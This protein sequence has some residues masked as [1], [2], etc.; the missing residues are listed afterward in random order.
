VPK[1]N[2]ERNTFVK[3]LITEASPLTFPENASIA[4]D[5]FVLHREGSRQRRLGM[6]YE[7]SHTMLN[8]GLP[9][10]SFISTAITGFR[11]ENADNNPL[12]TLCCVQVGEMLWFLDGFKDNLSGNVKGS[13]PLSSLSDRPTLAAQH[14]IQYAAI[15][16]NLILVNKYFTHPQLIEIEVDGGGNI[17]FFNTSINIKV[18]DIWGVGETTPV[19]DRPDLLTVEH[20]YNLFNQG[21]NADMVSITGGGTNYP[22]VAFKSVAGDWPSNADM[23]HVGKDGSDNFSANLILNSTIG[24]R[25]AG[26]G[27]VLL[28]IF[29]RGASRQQFMTD[30][31]DAV[32]RGN[33]IFLETITD[34]TRDA[35]FLEGWDYS[36]IQDVQ[37]RMN[38]IV[39]NTS[40]PTRSVDVSDL[41]LDAES[42]A[43]TTVTAYAG[44]IFYAGVDSVVTEGDDNTPAYASTIFFSQ[45]G[46]NVDNLSKCYSINDPTS[47]D[48]NTPLATD[49]GTITIPEASRILKLTSTGT[50]LIVV[51][52][53]GVWEISGPDGVFKA[54]DFSIS[55]ITNIGAT[56]A[57]SIVDVEGSVF[58]WSKAGIYQLVADKI[59]GRLSAVNISE[60]TIQTFYTSI[61]SVGR[62]N[63]IGRYD[64]DGRKLSWLYNDEESYD[65]VNQKNKYNRELVL[66]TVL[67]AFYTNTIGA[68]ATDSSYVAGYIP[69]G[70]FNIATDEQPVT[71]NGEIVEVNGE[72]VV[73]SSEVRSRGQSSTK[74]ITIKPNSTGDVTFTFS[75]Y[76]DQ[77]FVDW[78]SDDNVGVDAPAHLITGYE[79]FQDT[80]RSKYL[81][82]LVMHFKMTETGVAASGTDFNYITPAS[83][84]VSARWDFSNSTAGGKFGS[85]FQAYR[86]PRMY[87]PSMA[88]PTLD[89]GQEV[90]TTKNRLR[91]SGRAFSMRVDSEAG[92]DLYLYG[93]GIS[94]EGGDS[95]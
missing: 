20:E 61:P 52:E 86:L 53:N 30:A 55:R 33:S 60:T 22:H 28:D 68:V 4:E 62:T 31:E 23:V 70:G 5:N 13:V 41:P 57:G 42:G 59:S 14:P 90:I 43:L 87:T 32:Y 50:S 25:Q 58:Y 82:Y 56:N 1:A 54:D 24:S 63:A 3:G 64:S 51:S 21:W 94:V 78:E 84:L 76:S 36:A 79:L 73:V 88:S 77:D 18:R 75:L 15:N 49:G 91:G 8:S 12:I 93:W 35:M 85:Q 74:Y 10:Y 69:T 47:E 45:L 83:C 89:Y 6:D 92:K 80:M 16:G 9:L 66:D 26:R 65:G 81:P 11:W 34:L 67:G 29:A 38:W 95:V 2:L 40:Y 48:Y 7:A 17:D 44:R 27:S 37:S 71:H 46:E 39:G 19:D 72:P